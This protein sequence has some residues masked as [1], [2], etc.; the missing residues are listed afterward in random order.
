MVLTVE[1]AVLPVGR[2]DRARG[3][4][5]HRRADRGRSPGH[6]RGQREP[7][8]RPSP[9]G[10]RSGGVDGPASRLTS[11]AAV[12]RR[13]GSNRCVSLWGEEAPPWNGMTRRRAMERQDGPRGA[14]SHDRR[15][16]AAVAEVFR[17]GWADTTRRLPS[18][19]GATYAAKRRAA[20]SERFPGERIV[21]PSGGL[22]ARSNDFDCRRTC[23]ATRTRSRRGWTRCGKSAPPAGRPGLRR[24][25][26]GGCGCGC[27]GGGRTHRVRQVRGD[28]RGVAV[29]PGPRVQARLAGTSQSR[30]CVAVGGRGAVRAGRITSGRGDG[31][32]PGEASTVVGRMRER[33]VTR[34][35]RRPDGRPGCPPCPARSSP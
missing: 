15:A 25:A 33:P 35:C 29:L 4:P 24:A 12:P 14:R 13:R 1:P 28:G 2:P 10:R 16:P 11:T 7:L 3:A 18:V 17:Q 32:R 26:A 8:G 23:H 34:R 9:G 19:S 20:A 31:G 30:R 22:K 21:V 5:R 27:G 6:R